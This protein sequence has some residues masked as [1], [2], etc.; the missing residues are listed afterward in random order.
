MDDVL[1]TTNIISGVV[2][3]KELMS[4]NAIILDDNMTKILNIFVKRRSGVGV[5]D[6][7]VETLS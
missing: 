1:S 3:V 5:A 7:S 4:I 2:D 6:S